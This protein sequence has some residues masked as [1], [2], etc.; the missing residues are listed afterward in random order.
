MTIIVTDVCE[1]GHPLSEHVGSA[2]GENTVC[3]AWL[4]EQEDGRDFYGVC[5]CVRREDESVAI[6]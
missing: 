3:V 1:C 4:G 5:P 2:W 6:A